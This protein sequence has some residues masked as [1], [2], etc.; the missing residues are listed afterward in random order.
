MLIIFNML[1]LA[2]QNLANSALALSFTLLHPA[3]DRCQAAFCLER[4]RL[5]QTNDA[6]RGEAAVFDNINGI[7]RARRGR[8]GVSPGSRL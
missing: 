7:K 1:P 6:G 2:P 8:C 4:R 5:S 3:L